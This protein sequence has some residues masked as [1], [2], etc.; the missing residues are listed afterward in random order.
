MTSGVRPSDE[1]PVTMRAQSA[2]YQKAWGVGSGS[3][4]RE[5]RVRFAP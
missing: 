3:I 4:R 1:Q 2:K 5:P